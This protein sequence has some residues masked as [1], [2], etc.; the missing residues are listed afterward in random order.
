[1][2]GIKGPF[3]PDVIVMRKH[4]SLWHSCRSTCIDQCTALARF[5]LAHS[6][7]HELQ[8]H[9]LSF[10]DEPLVLYNFIWVFIL[11]IVRVVIDDN[12]VNTTISQEVVVFLG[13]FSILCKDKFGG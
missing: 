3:G 4:D 9:S 8:I 11:F 5:D 1:M 6:L 10:S 12:D 7:F 2:E 13:L